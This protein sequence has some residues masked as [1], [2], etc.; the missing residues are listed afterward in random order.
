MI[1]VF[2]NFV[3][4]RKY[5]KYAMMQHFYV[6]KQALKKEAALLVQK[7]V[8]QE[9]EDISYL[10]FEELRKVASTYQLDYSIITKRKEDHEVFEKLTPPRV[11]TSDGEII[12]CEYDTCD[13]PN[14]G[15][16]NER[17]CRN[18]GIVNVVFPANEEAG[19]LFGFSK[20]LFFVIPLPYERETYCRR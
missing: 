6:Y 3:G 15:K 10:T 20:W 4:F 5:P 9:P 19:F 13:I 2:R 17:V 12:A 8:I 11:M 1:S 18:P 14:P 7:G 16:R